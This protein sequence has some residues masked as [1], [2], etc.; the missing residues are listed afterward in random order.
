MRSS[1]GNA[2]AGLVCDE[3]GGSL[4]NSLWTGA[5]ITKSSPPDTIG[6][7]LAAST[8][9]PFPPT[10]KQPVSWGHTNTRPPLSPAAS[11]GPEKRYAAA[12]QLGNPD[13][14]WPWP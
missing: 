6:P 7:S 1:A 8:E 5:D 13:V 3:F 12:G 10:L 9:R 4:P 2:M 11:S 14:T